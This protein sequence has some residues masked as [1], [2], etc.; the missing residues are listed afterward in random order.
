MANPGKK[1][2]KKHPYTA[3]VEVYHIENLLQKMLYFCVVIE[4]T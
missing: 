3:E 4:N 2:S 1:R